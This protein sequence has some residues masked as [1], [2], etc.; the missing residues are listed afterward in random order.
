[1]TPRRLLLA[2]PLVLIAGRAEA[3][4]YRFG[5]LMIGHAWCEPSDGPTT[6]AMM[7]LAV[8]GN[9]GDTLTGASTPAAEAVELRPDPRGPAASRWEIA[10]RRPVAMRPDGP[11]LLLTGLKRP[12]VRGDRVPLDL[13][14]ERSGMR[15]V[16]LWVERAP[17]SG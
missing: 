7:P 3:H 15:Q 10:A 1:M 17:Y 5:E 4:S 16:E 9:R 2:A 11:H 14:F 8:T 12:L 13:R 6:R